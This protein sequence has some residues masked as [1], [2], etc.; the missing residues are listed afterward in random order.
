MKESS[1]TFSLTLLALMS[2][3]TLPVELLI[4]I[5]E[6]A[7]TNVGPDVGVSQ[8]AGESSKKASCPNGLL[9][10]TKLTAAPA[11]LSAWTMIRDSGVG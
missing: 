5:F 9:S 7:M 3:A 8:L 11:A 1:K 6:L 10:S 4:E 2:T